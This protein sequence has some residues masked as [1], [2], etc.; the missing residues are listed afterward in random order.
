L[1]LAVGLGVMVLPAHAA[2]LNLVSVGVGKFKGNYVGTLVGCDKDAKDISKVFLAQQG[3]LF[4]SV[5][6]T[7]L[8]DEQASAENILKALQPLRAKAQADTYTIFYVGSHG[9]NCNGQYGFCAYDK[10]V[11]WSSIQAALDGLPGRVFVILDTCG[12]GGATPGKSIIVIS[13]CLPGQSAWGD[14]VQG[15]FTKTFVAGLTG[16]ADAN[17]DGKITLAEIDAYVANELEKH[18]KGKLPKDFQQCTVLRPA[19]VPSSLP[20]ALLTVSPGLHKNLT[21]TQWEGKEI[22]EGF[23][24]LNFELL[25]NGKAISYDLL[26]RKYTGT[27]SHQGDKVWINLPDVG[28]YYTGTLK[29]S[30]ITGQGKDGT[31]GT[32]NFSVSLVK[33]VANTSWE[34]KEILAGF[35]KL[36]FTFEAG[37]TGSMTD[38]KEV[39]SGTWSQIGTKVTIDLP[40]IGT[41]YTGTVMGTTFSGQGKDGTHGTWNFS[42]SQQ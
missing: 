9:G 12:A 29:G 6:V 41:S 25:A 28:T 24:K 33:N 42:V 15:V 36:K 39:Y 1:T 5:S 31:H 34:G 10:G 3:K 11:P 7:Q 30:T 27:W 23:G 22:V 38:G 19:D 37:G 4:T 14:A 2:T 17:K 26:E 18:N 40:G 13:S 8:I 16:Q 32:W 35:D 21:N 20:L